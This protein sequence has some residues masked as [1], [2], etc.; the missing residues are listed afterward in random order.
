M[1]GSVSAR[2]FGDGF[3]Q[4]ELEHVEKAKQEQT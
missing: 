2:I 1:M 3:L 4:G